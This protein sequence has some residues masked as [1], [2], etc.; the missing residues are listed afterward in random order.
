MSTSLRLSCLLVN[1]CRSS[2]TH[3]LIHLSP[4]YFVANHLTGF[5]S[6]SFSPRVVVPTFLAH[7]RNG[8]DR[9]MC[10]WLRGR[11]T[12]WDAGT[13]AMLSS[14]GRGTGCGSCAEFSVA[15]TLMNEECAAES[16][17]NRGANSY[18]ARD[19]C[20]DCRCSQNTDG[21]LIECIRRHPV[22]SCLVGI[23][24]SG[25]DGRVKPASSTRRFCHW[26]KVV[27]RKRWLTVRY[28]L[29]WLLSCLR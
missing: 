10:D 18:S 19:G 25:R 17:S 5:I 24:R 20:P 7:N 21:A 29:T 9:A 16:T 15:T 1:R 6:H 13:Q 22:R 23:E 14:V 28:Q 12:D 4:T 3:S 8:F 26:N 11:P 2:L 27:D